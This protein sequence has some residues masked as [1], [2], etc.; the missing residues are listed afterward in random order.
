MLETT[1]DVLFRLVA[2]GQGAVK[3]EALA[4][5]ECFVENPF[6]QYGY[7]PLKQLGVATVVSLEPCVEV[8]RVDT[9]HGATHLLDRKR[10]VTSPLT[11]FS[12]SQRQQRFDITVLGRRQPRQYVGE[13][14]VRVQAIGL[15]RSDQAHD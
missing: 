1:V 9:Q 4:L 6:D 12:L 3:N 10:A 11:A 7:S 15:G 13:P 8:I 2:V 5:S 14:R